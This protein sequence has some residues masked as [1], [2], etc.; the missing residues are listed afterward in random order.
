MIVLYSL[1]FIQNK[2]IYF[3]KMITDTVFYND[4]SSAYH[5]F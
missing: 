1:L 2:T 5:S 3:D 4:C